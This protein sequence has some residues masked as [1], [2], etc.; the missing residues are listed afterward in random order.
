MAH[1][2]NEWANPSAGPNYS[3]QDATA[4]SIIAYWGGEISS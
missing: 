4:N 3:G 1:D 2:D